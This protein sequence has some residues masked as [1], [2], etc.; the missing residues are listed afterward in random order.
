VGL[1]VRMGRSML[2]VSGTVFEEDDRVYA[3]VHQTSVELFQRMMG[4]KA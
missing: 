3:L 2:P 1:I 4:W